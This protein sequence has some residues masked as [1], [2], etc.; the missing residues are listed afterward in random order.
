[1]AAPVTP[2][3]PAG[4]A[5]GS[6][7]CFVER[8]QLVEGSGDQAAQLGQIAYETHP[9]QVG[10]EDDHRR[11][12]ADRVNLDLGGDLTVDGE[13]QSPRPTAGAARI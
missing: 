9:A 1:M 10:A 7:G 13:G 12:A 6:L 2:R 11:L 8:D 4:A 5:T 3:L